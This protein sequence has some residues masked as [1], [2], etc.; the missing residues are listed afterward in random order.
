VN[1]II[2][3]KTRQNLVEFLSANNLRTSFAAREGSLTM[4]ML[5][6]WTR[7]PVR[8]RRAFMRKA[9]WIFIAYSVSIF[10]IFLCF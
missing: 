7:D 4:K 8:E 3:L 5:S 6:Y 1:V 2:K 9:A 10:I